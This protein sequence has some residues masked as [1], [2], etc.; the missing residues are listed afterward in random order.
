MGR[1]L[2]RAGL[3]HGADLNRLPSATG[4][5]IEIGVKGSWLEDTL[6]GSFA[7]FKT[8]QNNVASYV[9]YDSTNLVSI[10]EGIDT[11]SRGFELELA[12]AATPRLALSA[13]YTQLAIKDSAGNDTRSF[14]PRRVLRLST[15]YRLPVFEKLKL[16]AS[17]NWRSET[18]RADTTS[19]GATA[20]T[21]QPAYALLN[22]MA[23][24]DIS[25]R[26][27]A[28]LN[29][30]NVTDEKYL[31]SLHWSQGFYGAPRNGSVS[32]NWTY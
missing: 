11:F 23:R 15:T 3:R 17:V 9:A 4:R 29:I 10:Y 26:L 14:S 31:T 7:V 12:G 27:N 32:L 28:T 20:N 1:Q 22:L 2:R 30:H 6:T 8:R 25:D 13:G 5:N 18:H 19:S 16:G 21:R 24:Y